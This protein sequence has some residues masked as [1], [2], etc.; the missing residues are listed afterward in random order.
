M[1]LAEVS[2]QYKKITH[3]CIILEELETKSIPFVHDAH[4]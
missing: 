2:L 4:Q 3:K 1:L